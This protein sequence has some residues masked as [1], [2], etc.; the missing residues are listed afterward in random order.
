[1]PGTSSRSA[2]TRRDRCRLCGDTHLELVLPITASPIA[3]AYVPRER[4][5]EAQ[6]A[7]PLDLYLCGA[8]GHVQNIDVVDPEI[9]FRDYMYVTS[10]S[11][12]LIEHYRRY[13]DDVVARFEVRPGSLVLEIGSNDGSLLGFFKAKGLNVLGIDPARRIAEDATARGILTLPEFFGSR[14]AEEI[15]MKSGPAAVVAANNVFAHADNLDDIVSGIRGMLDDD[16]IF[17]FEVSY[18]PDIVDRFLFDTIYHEHVSYH[19]IVPLVRFFESLGMQL[20]DVQ[21]IDSKGGSIRGFAQRSPEGR[22]AVTPRVRELIA[23]EE[24]RHFAEPA[25]FREFGAAIARRKVAVAAVVDDARARGKTVA[26]YG[27]STTVTTLMWHFD[28]TEKLEFLA[29]DNP[30]KQGLFAPKC[31]LPVLPSQ[32]LYARR[33]DYVVILA[34]NYAQ[35]IM[36]RH[37][38]YIAEGGTFVIPLPDIKLVSAAQ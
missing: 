33:P 37:R 18:L 2:V 30:L 8:C 24:R 22:R 14:L 1:M 32:E 10:S 16:G 6:D 5:A 21:R 26:G 11:L 7:Y 9:L 34:W 25:V 38:R 28:L 31:H 23:E 15:R 36:E 3:D 20:F 29:D 35:P 17:I 4:L 27:A 19:S 13:A 12:G